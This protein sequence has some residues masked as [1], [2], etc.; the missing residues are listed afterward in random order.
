MPK[1][2]LKKDKGITQM[3]IDYMKKFEKENLLR[4]QKLKRVRQRNFLTGLLLGAGVLSIYTYS[5]VA[6]KQEKFL[7]DFED[8]VEQSK[9]L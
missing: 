1:V 8:P 3:H 5:I 6:V 4:V 2:D 7:D 9:E